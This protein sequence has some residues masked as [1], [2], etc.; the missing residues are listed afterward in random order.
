M[1]QK[2]LENPIL[3]AIVTIFIVAVLIFA[4]HTKDC[5]CVE[6]WERMQ[7]RK[8]DRQARRRQRHGMVDLSGRRLTK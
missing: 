5:D 8:K 3:A 7:H 4:Y 1:F 6:A 2:I